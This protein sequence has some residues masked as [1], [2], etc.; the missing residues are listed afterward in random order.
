MSEVKPLLLI[1]LLNKFAHSKNGNEARTFRFAKYGRLK[2]HTETDD[3]VSKRKS[4]LDPHTAK[5]AESEIRKILEGNLQGKVSKKVWIDPEMKMRALPLQI[6]TGQSGYGTMTTGSKIKIPDCKKVRA[7]TYWEKVDDIDLACFGINEEGNHREFSWRSM[8]NVNKDSS[9][10]F[11]GDEVSGYD[12]GSEYFDVDLEKFKENFP[13]YR[14]L[15][16]T[17]N[18]F[19]RSVSFKDCFATAG[20]MVR[21][22]LDSGEVFEPKTVKSSFRLTADGNF[23]YL[24]AIDVWNREMIWLNMNLDHSCHVAGDTAMEFMLEYLDRTDVFNLY[25]L[26]AACASEVVEN[27]RVADLLITDKELYGKETVHSWET[28]KIFPL[29]Q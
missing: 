26:Y 6:S 12:G 13:E 11:S 5:V 9:I 25:D 7:F 28:E 21:D 18:I 3:E 20:F 15:I 24:F 4:D 1:Q 22:I 27:W 17:D 23:S 8:W 14:Y 10:S 29:L 19:S 16:F 2:V